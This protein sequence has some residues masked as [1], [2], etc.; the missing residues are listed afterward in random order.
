M[1]VFTLADVIQQNEDHGGGASQERCEATFRKVKDRWASWDPAL[2]QPKIQAILESRRNAL[3]I[4]NIPLDLGFAKKNPEEMKHRT[5]ATRLFN[6]K[7][8]DSGWSAAE[9]YYC[10]SKIAET[11][12]LAARQATDPKLERGRQLDYFTSLTFSPHEVLPEPEN[13]DKNPLWTTRR[14]T[15]KSDKIAGM[16]VAAFTSEYGSGMISLLAVTFPWS[17]LAD[18]SV[19]DVKCF[20]KALRMASNL[21]SFKKIVAAV[22]QFN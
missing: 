10:S 14:K 2:M 15:I 12:E 11:M 22:N 9:R 17:T 8:Q 7:A 18:F 16:K 3:N 5:M 20:R 13:L 6:L 19:L 1:V 4:S 21:D